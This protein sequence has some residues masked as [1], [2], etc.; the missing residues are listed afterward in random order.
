MR[1]IAS[2]AP[3]G[4]KHSDVLSLPFDQRQKSRLRCRLDSGEEVALL[5]PRGRVLRGG[6]LL[7]ASDGSVVR[8]DA[9]PE[10][11]SMVRTADPTALARVAYHLGNRHIAVQIGPGFLRYQHD[12]VLDDMVRALG[13][14]VLAETAPFEP[15]A[16]AYGREP[17]HHDHGEHHQSDHDHAH[18][19]GQEH[20]HRRR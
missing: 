16:G 3:E 5:M 15:E 20:A 6:D 1:T 2:D 18:H 9:A 7:G 19:H 17:H 13:L 14:P 4:S 8:V 10:Q 11:V 12:H